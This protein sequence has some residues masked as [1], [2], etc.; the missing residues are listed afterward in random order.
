MADVVVHEFVLTT[1]G[2]GA[3]RVARQSEIGVT[4]EFAAALAELAVA[5]REAVFQDE[6]CPQAA[7]QS[8]GASHAPTVA[9]QHTPPQASIVRA[10]FFAAGT[11]VD[12]PPPGFRQPSK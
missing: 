6:Q 1:H 9:W 10:L 12:Y 11:T 7:T 5:Q 3:E 8:F 4:A 2:Y